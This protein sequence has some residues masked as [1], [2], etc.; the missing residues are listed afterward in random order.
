[1]KS[2]REAADLRADLSYLYSLNN[3]GIKPGLSR[4]QKLLAAIGNP[5]NAYKIVHIA[6]TNGKGSTCAIIASILRSAGLRV[7]LYTS[8]HLLRF[9]ERIRVDDLE[10]G[11]R[12]IAQFIRHWRKTIDELDCSFFEATTALAFDYF[13]KQKAEYVVLETG[14]GGRFDATNVVQPEVTVITPVARDHRSF[15]AGVYI[16]LLLKKPA[17]LK[18]ALPAS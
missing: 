14:M 7:G 17:L 3:R 6:G 12:Q 8:P 11:D 10:I 9:N 18:A 1:M 15:L 16:R 13:K 2:S 5:Q 4:I